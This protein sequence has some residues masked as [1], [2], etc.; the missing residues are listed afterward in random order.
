MNSLGKI[1]PF[2]LCDLTIRWTAACVRSR[3]S[4]GQVLPN[5]FTPGDSA[6][7]RSNRGLALCARN[8]PCPGGGAGGHLTAPTPHDRFAQAVF[9]DPK[10][11]EA[12]FRAVLPPELTRALDFERATL[13]PSLFHDDDLHQ[14][15]A[16]FLFEVPLAGSDAYLLTLLEHQ[17]SQDPLM[18]ARLLVYAGRALDRFL[19]EHPRARRLPALIP[20]VLYHG[21]RSGGPAGLPRP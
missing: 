20:I 11:A 17:S 6:L 2:D 10:Q 12:V 9:S 21:A 8:G 5:R 1:C 4:I 7:K 16:D 13:L 18:A 14:R 15:R 19:R 3:G